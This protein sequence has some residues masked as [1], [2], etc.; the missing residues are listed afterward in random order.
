[1]EINLKYYLTSLKR[2]F[3]FHVGL[4]KLSSFLKPGLLYFVDNIP[5]K[6]QNR[7]SNYQKILEETLK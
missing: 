4:F 5:R 6:Q 3:W 1:M 7:V 2:P